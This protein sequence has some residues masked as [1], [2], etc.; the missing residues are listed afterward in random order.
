MFHLRML[1]LK[2]YNKSEINI[3]YVGFDDFDVGMSVWLYLVMWLWVVE[4]LELII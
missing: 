1:A 4:F 2:F 3:N